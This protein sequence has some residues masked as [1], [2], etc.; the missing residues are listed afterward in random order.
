MLQRLNIYVIREVIIKSL[1]TLD[2]FKAHYEIYLHP[3]IIGSRILAIYFMLLYK[4][5][6]KSINL[7]NHFIVNTTLWRRVFF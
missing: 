7:L 4:S 2:F 6:N 3:M 1:F 5:N